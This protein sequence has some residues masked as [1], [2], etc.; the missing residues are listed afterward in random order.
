[1]YWTVAVYGMLY[2]FYFIY[3]ILVLKLPTRSCKVCQ[4]KLK[5]CGNIWAVVRSSISMT[6]MIFFTSDNVLFF[7]LYFLLLCSSAT[8]FMCYPLQPTTLT[9]IFLFTKMYT[10]FVDVILY[11][12]KKCVYFCLILFECIRCWYL[13]LKLF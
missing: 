5:F 2:V 13:N 12:H 8:V 4:M 11:I 3:K 7:N 10:V 6:V 1:M 9:C